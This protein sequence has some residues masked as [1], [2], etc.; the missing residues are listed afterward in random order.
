MVLYFYSEGPYSSGTEW[1]LA[2]CITKGK[3]QE[4]HLG[5]EKILLEECVQ[6]FSFFFFKFRN[7]QNKIAYCQQYRFD[8][9]R[10]QVSSK[11]KV[12]VSRRLRKKREGDG[13]TKREY[14]D[15]H[16]LFLNCDLYPRLSFMVLNTLHLLKSYF[17]STQIFKTQLYFVFLFAKSVKGTI[18]FV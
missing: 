14:K 12:H 7:L 11:H 17:V 6:Y 9:V 3:C 18:H 1:I 4:R 13:G 5:D 15:R 16:F 8:E 10:K 2:P